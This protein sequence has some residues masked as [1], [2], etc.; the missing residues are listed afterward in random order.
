MQSLLITHI[1]EYQ[2]SVSLEK[3]VK[4]KEEKSS[5][6]YETKILNNLDFNL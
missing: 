2:K 6:D 4:D 5:V 1:F 3:E